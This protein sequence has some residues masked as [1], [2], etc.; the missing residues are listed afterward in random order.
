MVNGENTH[1]DMLQI[2]FTEKKELKSKEFQKLLR[3]AL[4]E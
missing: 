4:E 2:K 3:E 1:Y